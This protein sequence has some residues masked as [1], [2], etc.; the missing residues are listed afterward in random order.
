M[1]LAIEANGLRDL[2]KAKRGW[3]TTEELRNM[4]YD[5]DGYFDT[6]N[7][8]PNSIDTNMLT[9]HRLYVER[10]QITIVRESDL[11]TRLLS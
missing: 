6:D 7:I 8:R 4:V 5:T 10:Q 1:A 9:R 3:R 11:I 2:S